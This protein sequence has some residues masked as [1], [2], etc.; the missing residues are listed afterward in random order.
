MWYGV[1]QTEEVRPYAEAKSRRHHHPRTLPSLGQLPQ[2]QE[3]VKFSSHF[4][5][6]YACFPEAPDLDMPRGVG[7]GGLDQELVVRV[8]TNIRT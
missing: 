8:L 5:V 3:K 7:S 4:P 2:G 1:G 6:L